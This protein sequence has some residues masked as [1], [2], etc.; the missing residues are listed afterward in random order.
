MTGSGFNAAGALKVSHETHDGQDY[1]LLEG[2][3]N[4]G[5]DPEFKVSI[6]GHH[7]LTNHD[8]NL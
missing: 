2:N 5:S 8:F 1:T 6:K 3:T 4:G 7:N